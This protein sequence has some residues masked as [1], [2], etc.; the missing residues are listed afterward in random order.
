MQEPS[1]REE[2]QESTE[3]GEWDE[4]RTDQ[5]GNEHGHERD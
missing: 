4:E 1:G 5:V 2:Q 3:T